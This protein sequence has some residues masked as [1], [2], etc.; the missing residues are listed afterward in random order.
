MM[1]I[2]TDL[3]AGGITVYGSQGCGWT[4]KQLAYLEQ[5]GMAYTFIDC[6][7][8]ACPGFVEAFPTLDIDGQLSVG[9]Q[10][11]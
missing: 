9:F 5:I 10:E 4:Q 7:R 2:K 3:Q 6:D 8:Q 1:K 11:L